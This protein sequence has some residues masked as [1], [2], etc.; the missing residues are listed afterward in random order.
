MVNLSIIIVNWNSANYLKKCISSIFRNNPTCSFE[1]I[2]IDNNSDD[3]SLDSAK[4][5]FPR[6]RIIK[7]SK[8][9]GLAKANNEGI[10]KSKGNYILF[11]NPDAV[12]L[13]QAIDKMIAY[14]DSHP[15]TGALGP[16]LLNKNNTVQQSIHGFISL[17]HAFF[18]I[19]SLDRFFPKN[20]LNKIFLGKLLGN[21]FK[22]LLAS[23]NEYNKPTK[24]SV[25]MGSCFLTTKK[26]LNN[27]G[28]FD[29]HF[30]LYHEENELCY[31]IKEK[32]FDCVYFPIAKVV[33]YNKQSAGKVLNLVF[34]ERCKSIFYYF[35]KHFKHKMVFLKVVGFVAITINIF[36]CLLLDRR[37]M[38]SRLSIMSYVLRY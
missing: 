19:S 16:K 30:F 32:G 12:I 17:S 15:R 21:I 14:F 20:A 22:N 37:S 2:I 31:R 10:R 7:N 38:K 18:E 6:L 36:F 3:K 27:T 25:V 35:E 29:E 13:P 33:H 9:L 34:I 24:V 26:I 23:Y 8:N 4:Y 11:L 1:V 5:F 28:Y